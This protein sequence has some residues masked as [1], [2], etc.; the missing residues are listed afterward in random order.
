MA[1]KVTHEIFPSVTLS[2]KFELNRY[3]DR[4]CSWMLDKIGDANAR[5]RQ[6][7]IDAALAMADHPAIGA[8]LWQTQIIKGRVKKSAASSVRHIA[9]KLTLLAKLIEKTQLKGLNA[10]AAVEFAVGNL[11][12]SNAD[13][14]NAAYLVLLEVYKLKGGKVRQQFF[15]VRPAQLEVIEKAFRE[16][17]VG[18]L[19]GAYSLVNQKESANTGGAVSGGGV[20]SS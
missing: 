10:E 19:Q 18:N 8:D 7:V 12:N 16:V 14:R 13:V 6:S 11:Q 20:S 4:T 2:S 15:G 1:L 3:I 17:D 9:G 5:V